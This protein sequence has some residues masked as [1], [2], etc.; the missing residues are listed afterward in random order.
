MKKS[1]F[2]LIL[3][4]G[5]TMS[6]IAATQ[7]VTLRVNSMTCEG[8]KAKINKTLGQERGVLKSVIDLQERTVKISYN[9]KR[10]DVA[11]LQKALKSAKYDSQVLDSTASENTKNKSAEK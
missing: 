11:Q 2:T 8:C 7:T 5:V 9:D 6:A 3:F 4:I 1:I 10:T